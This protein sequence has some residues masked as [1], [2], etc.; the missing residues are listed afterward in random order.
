MS[1]TKLRNQITNWGGKLPKEYKST[2][3][4]INQDLKIQKLFRAII[5]APSFAGKTNLVFHIIKHS[6]KIYSH[7]HIIA[8][9]PDQELYN[10]MRD[11]LKDFIT[12]YDPHNP[13]KLDDIKAN[14]SLQLVVIDDFSN[15]KKLQKDVFSHYFTRGRHKLLSTIFLSHS[16]F[17]TDKMIRLN[18]AYVMILKANSKRDLFM[19]LKDFNIPNVTEEGLLRAYNQATREKGQFLLVDSVNG[20]LRQNFGRVAGIYLMPIIIYNLLLHIEEMTSIITLSSKHIV[21]NGYNNTLTYS[22]PNS[23]INFKNNQVAICGI[24][25]F[26]SQY[27]IDSSQ[28]GNTSFSIQMP[29]AA[30]FSSIAINLPDGYY[31]YAD[32]NNY[33]QTQ[34]IA[35]GAYLIDG[36]SNNVYYVKLTDNSTYY[37]AQLDLSPVP[38]ALPSGWSRPSTGLYSLSGTGLPATGYTPKMTFSLDLQLVNTH[39]HS[40]LLRCNLIDNPFSLPPDVLTSFTSQGTSIGQL[41]DV[42]P[43]EFSWIDIADGSRPNV[44]LVIVDQLERF[45]KFR[46]NQIVIQLLIRTKP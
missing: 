24:Q 31:S 5:L 2:S 11:K 3:H 42:K 4:G 25:M 21:N 37:A 32:I 39:H 14:G 22:F 16:Y 17:A 9:N 12:I 10:Y 35:A 40:Y 13:P 38:T 36:S 41:I 28:Y 8:R 15:D 44:T 34:L 46:D 43:N 30:T 7:L 29:T 20:E 6:P 1:N 33:I 18:S 45:V 26:N 19:V 23:S 27:N